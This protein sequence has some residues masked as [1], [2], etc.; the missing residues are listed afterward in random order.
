VDGDATLEH[1]VLLVHQS[2]EGLLG[3]GDEGQLVGHLEDREAELARL[4]EQRGGQGVEV[5]AGTEAEAGQMAPGQQPHELALALLGVE[6]D[7]G[8]Q[9]QLTAGQPRRGIRQLRDVDP[10][11]R[12]VGSL[13]AGCQLEAHLCDKAPNGEHPGAPPPPSA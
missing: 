4:L 5:E 10:A 2:G 6:L 9:Q 12:S 13:S 8:G 7:S 11:D 1:L 3:Q